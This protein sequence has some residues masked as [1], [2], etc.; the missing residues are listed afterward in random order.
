MS[1]NKFFNTKVLKMMIKEN[2]E[3]HKN[4]FFDEFSTDDSIIS[5]TDYDKIA[6]ILNA[7]LEGKDNI[8]I[9][10]I[11]MA[12]DI[13]LKEKNY[14]FDSSIDNKYKKNINGNY[15]YFGVIELG[16]YSSVTSI[17]DL[18][19]NISD[20]MNKNYSKLCK[21]TKVIDD[22][23]NINIVKDN[24]TRFN[25]DNN[26]AIFKAV[27]NLQTKNLIFNFNLDE[28]FKMSH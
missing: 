7:N 27:F 22:L 1:N 16:Y 8:S 15:F 13:F 28:L 18:L 17:N 4:I 2:V 3:N 14:V 10:D 20:L 26:K 24:S 23:V 6:E 12:I 5:D 19:F 9:T 25:C 11:D 21:S